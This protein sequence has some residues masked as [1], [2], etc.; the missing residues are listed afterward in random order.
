MGNHNYD[1]ASSEDHPDN[2]DAI[3][4][5]DSHEAKLDTDLEDQTPY[6]KQNRPSTSLMVWIAI[7]VLAT[8]GIVST[9]SL[10]C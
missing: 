5:L 7:N 2:E 8:I 6:E 9:L 1:R 3:S 10:Q 4:L